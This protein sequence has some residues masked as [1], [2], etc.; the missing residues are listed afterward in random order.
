[1]PLKAHVA[2]GRLPGWATP[3]LDRRNLVS[4]GVVTLAGLSALVFVHAPFR[5]GILSD[6]S[7][8]EMV[9]DSRGTLLAATMALEDFGE[10]VLGRPVQVLAGDTQGDPAVAVDVATSWLDHNQAAVLLDSGPSSVGRALAALAVRRGEIVLGVGDPAASPCVPTIFQFSPS[11]SALATAGL[12]PA[13]DAGV[14]R[15]FCITAGGDR[16]AALQSLA[17]QTI[18]GRGGTVVGAIDRR[19]GAA[20]QALAEQVRRSGATGLLF[21]S[22]GADFVDG[23]RQA[24]DLGITEGRALVGLQV[25][26]ADVAALGPIAAGLQFATVFHPAMTDNALSW[27]RRFVSRHRDR[28]PG[29]RQA[30]AYSATLH[31]LRAVKAVGVAQSDRIAP[32]MRAQP[33]R[34]VLV[35]NAPIRSDGR[36]MIDI[37]IVQVRSGAGSDLLDAVERIGTWPAEDAYAASACPARS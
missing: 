11:P 18:G 14:N 34:S 3:L 10:R 36:V 27:S 5:I 17:A 29:W 6:L 31:Y 16:G 24:R 35:R 26:L 8:P 25:D 9:D 37:E 4:A 12:R 28:P 15:W 19:F 33:V 13:L 2:P 32:W 1:M 20:D 23:F 7:T 21:A 30:L 22:A